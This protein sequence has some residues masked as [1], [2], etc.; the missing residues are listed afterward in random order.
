MLTYFK[1]LFGKI[2]NQV[3][4]FAPGPTV[5]DEIGLEKI[6]FVRSAN[7]KLSMNVLE[8]VRARFPNA[9][10][11]MFSTW[12]LDS[13]IILNSGLYDELIFLPLEHDK[14]VHKSR[15]RKILSELKSTFHPVILVIAS[16]DYTYYRMF[17]LPFFLRRGHLLI[18][19]ENLDTFYFNNYH[20]KVILK[21]VLGCLSLSYILGDSLIDIFCSSVK[22][23]LYII[24]FPF[25]YSSL[26]FRF[27]YLYFWKNSCSIGIK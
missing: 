1:L 17:I 13:Q 7:A 23:C 12:T 26:I 20:R 18:Y 6:L 11:T 27:L 5:D 19:N 2:K 25:R 24:T 3:G 21:H 9:N 16:S 8:K 10:V 15:K 22:G 4:F 14:S